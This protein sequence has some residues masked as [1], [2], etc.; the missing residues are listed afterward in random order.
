MPTPSLE[1]SSG[2][3]R[4][5]LIGYLGPIA[6]TAQLR[7]G[8][9]VSAA[10]LTIGVMAGLLRVI[11]LLC[12]ALLAVGGALAAATKDIDIVVTHGGGG[13]VTT[14]TWVNNST[15]TVRSDTS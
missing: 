5:R 10:V 8:G 15:A 14:H 2:W 13:I 3:R 12:A 1:G 7:L 6:I 9:W 11:A 4:T